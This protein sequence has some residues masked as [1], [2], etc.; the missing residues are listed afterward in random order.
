MKT[1]I[2]TKAVVV[3]VA[4]TLNTNFIF[5]Q[6]SCSATAG[7]DAGPDKVYS[8]GPCC[9]PP[10]IGGT[11]SLG[12]AGGNQACGPCQISYSWLPTTGL[13]N[14][15]I[16]N[17]TATPSATTNYTLTVTYTCGHVSTCPGAGGPYDCCLDGCSGSTCTTSPYCSGTQ[18]RT[19]VVKVTK[20]TQT[21]CARLNPDRQPEIN[22][23]KTKLYPNPNPGV[24]TLEVEDI[25]PN[26]TIHV[27]N[28]QGES[29]WGET[30]VETKQIIDISKESKGVYYLEMKSN[31]KVLFYKKIIVQ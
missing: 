13:S 15:N 18:N 28:M 17:P 9:T 27:Y 10:T 29:V 26:M 6:G 31:E 3:I 19:D 16:C 30:N 23:V 5:G 21:C 2:L 1:I 8:T 11:T 7:A 22:D 14:P 20:S 12:C 25:L 24:F 4:M